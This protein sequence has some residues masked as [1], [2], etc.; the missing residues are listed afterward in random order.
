MV[1]FLRDNLH[2]AFDI[3]NR[4]ECNRQGG[5]AVW[6]VPEP[7]R[8]AFNP[9]IFTRTRYLFAMEGYQPT[10]GPRPNVLTVEQVSS[11]PA[12]PRTELR[13]AFPADRDLVIALMI[14]GIGRSTQTI[15]KG[16]QSHQFIGIIDSII[17]FSLW[18]LAGDIGSIGGAEDFIGQPL[19][20]VPGLWDPGD[21]RDPNTSFPVGPAG[22]HYADIVTSAN[23]IY[24]L[25][26]TSYEDSNYIVGSDGAVLY[27]TDEVDTATLDVFRADGQPGTRLSAESFQGVTQ[28]DLSPVVRGWFDT[29]LCDSGAGA[30][31]G[32]GPFADGH[33]AVRYFVRGLGGQQTTHHFVALNAVAQIGENPVCGP[34]D[35][36]S[37]ARTLR[38]CEGY[39]LDYSAIDDAA[40][41][42]SRGVVRTPID[43]S[44]LPAA[45]TVPFGVVRACVPAQPFY[46][47]WVNPLGGVDYFMFSRR[48]TYK[49]SVKSSSTY[50]GYVPDPLRA[51]SN[52]RAWQ[53]TT[54]NTVTVGAGGLSDEE[55]GL[56]S[57]LPYAP[58][59][60][61]YDGGR[62]TR[63]AVAKFDGSFGTDSHM[64]SFEITFTLPQINTQF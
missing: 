33:L 28:F 55:L 41:A 10:R 51:P 15:K 40:A 63:L 43:A 21:F 13:L 1:N 30:G 9:I 31:R 60:E 36:L 39:P 8:R 64:H 34:G 32:S 24:I 57:G 19:A 61:W 42:S 20:G 23:Y 17:G 46:L 48:Q 5:I 49:P 3:A 35:Y 52:V 7:F 18:Q 27:V 14:V 12:D 4:H 56:L 16:A 59:I 62:W 22:S 53:I 58:T 45:G 38:L 6:D 25:P 37:Q 54:A 2:E 44:H 47:R 29:E 50:E 26:G 11:N